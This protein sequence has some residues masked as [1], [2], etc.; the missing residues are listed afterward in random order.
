MHLWSA[1]YT[2][3]Q[4]FPHAA[5]NQPFCDVALVPAGTY[6]YDRY[7]AAAPRPKVQML[8]PAAQVIIRRLAADSGNIAWTDHANARMKEREFTTRDVLTALRNGD[9]EDVPEP[10]KKT[11][12][13]RCK[14]V[15]KDSGRGRF[16]GVVTVI[17]EEK[18]LVVVTTQWE[19][20][21]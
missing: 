3:A 20:G 16:M 1:R 17:V 5:S 9:V 21:R 12:H 18:R 19:D 4:A 14:V 15:H 2:A 7:M 8:P 11:N 10:G 13:W 6:H